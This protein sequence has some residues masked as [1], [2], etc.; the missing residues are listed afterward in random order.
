MLKK[1]AAEFFGTFCLVLF[2]TGMI[3]VD[4]ITQEK[5]GIILVSGAFG[6]IVYLAIRFLGS[7]S[8]AHI[9]PAVTL[10]LGIGQRFEKDQILPYILSQIA[11]AFAASFCL[12][13]YF[14][15]DE[16]LGTTL[17]YDNCWTTAFALEFVLTFLLMTGILYIMNKRQALRGSFVGGIVFLEALFAG[18][19]CGAS[20][21][22]ARSLAPAIISGHT[23]HLWVYL[24][25]PLAGAIVATFVY[26]WFFSKRES[27]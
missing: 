9:N 26:D 6:L 17:P 7:I 23:E 15:G 14:E 13:S 27:A 3:V 5:S 11:G 1:L 4:G 12:R 8:G 2:G 10:A 18:P 16:F 21:N 20:M 24:V 19:Y 22:P 25:A